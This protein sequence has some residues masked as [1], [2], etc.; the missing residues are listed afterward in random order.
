MGMGEGV[1]CF[2]HIDVLKYLSNDMSL[3]YVTCIGD[4]LT[5]ATHSHVSIP[6]KDLS[7]MNV[8]ISVQ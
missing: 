6:R 3:M 4:H 2:V 1:S 5:K 7:L 8:M